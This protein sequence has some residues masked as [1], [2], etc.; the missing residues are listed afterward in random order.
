MDVQTYASDAQGT[1]MQWSDLPLVL[2]TT[3]V[4]AVLRLQRQT[5]LRMLQVGRLTGVK[6]GK[7]WRVARLEVERFMGVTRMQSEARKAVVN[8][9]PKGGRALAA[10]AEIDAETWANDPMTRLVGA[11]KGGPADLSSRHHEYYAEAVA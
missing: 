6:A 9:Q 7:D 2:T 3:E 4:A 11:F 5:V 8:Q 1:V 10:D